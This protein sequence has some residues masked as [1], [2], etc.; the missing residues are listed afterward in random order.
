MCQLMEVNM[1]RGCRIALFPVKSSQSKER[2]DE[3]NMSR[4]DR[5]T[6]INCALE[7]SLSVMYVL[8]AKNSSGSLM[9]DNVIERIIELCRFQLR[10]SIYPEF[11]PVYRQSGIKVKSDKQKRAQ[12]K[13]T[14]HSSSV[15][16]LFSRVADLL[17]LIGSL[18]GQVVLLDQYVIKIASI[19]I[20][21]FFVENIQK[22]QLSAIRCAT[23]IFSK[24][25][26]HRRSLL[27]D[28]LN[29]LARLPTTKRNL[30]N[31]R[32]SHLCDEDDDEVMCIQMLSALVLQ[33]WLKNMTL[34]RTFKEH[35]ILKMLK[36]SK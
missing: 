3:K 2:E 12:N 28:I 14:N 34:L 13:I 21:P 10:N 11:D 8:T 23:V 24:Y 33:V 5:I 20:S 22:I 7:A 18:A 29:S 25:P 26:D 17:L 27:D 36:T 30:R 19:A 35:W 6:A 15:L 32:L 1:R 9:S 4:Q 31:Y 16:R